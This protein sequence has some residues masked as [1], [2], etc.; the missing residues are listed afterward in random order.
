MKEIIEMGTKHLK[1]LFYKKII[2][3]TVINLAE[4]TRRAD[5]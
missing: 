5:H 4:R 2:L 1:I 3:K